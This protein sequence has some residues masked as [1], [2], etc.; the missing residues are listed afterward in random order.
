MLTATSEIRIGNAGMHTTLLLERS[1]RGTIVR[2][3]KLAY[4]TRYAAAVAGKI[5]KV[6]HIYLVVSGRYAPSVGEALHG[7]VGLILADDEIER[8][9]SKSR[10]FR[11]DGDT[12]HVIHLRYEQ[13]DIIAP[14]GMAAG[15]LD[16][17]DSFWEIARYVMDHPNDIG[18]VFDALA[19]HGITKPAVRIHDEPERYRRLWEALRPLYDAHGGTVSLKQLAASL[20]MS[21]RQVG[22]DAKDLAATFGFGNGFRDALLV[23]R[24]RV[25]VL[26]LSAPEASVAEVATA[27]GYGSPIAMA[28]A[29]RDAKL[30]AP[31][32]VQVAVRGE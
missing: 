17:P 4:D 25:A 3:D 19:A 27:V 6:G 10:T 16:L 13:G 31:S 30:P 9:T 15:R 32:A 21:M 26:L 11:T 29:F 23:L 7:P 5:E 14:V 8:L 24:L 18:H 12:I 2:R 28:R 20:D 22:R 1:V